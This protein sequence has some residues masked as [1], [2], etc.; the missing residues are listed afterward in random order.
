MLPIYQA[1]EI[2]DII[3]EAS[4]RTKPWVVF[5]ETSEGITPYVVK[6]FTTEQKEANCVTNEVICNVLAGEFGL[7]K[8]KMALIEIPENLVAQKSP[9]IQNQYY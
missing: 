9:E 1:K 5:A 6:L 3:P 2:V 8:P 4:G 7:A